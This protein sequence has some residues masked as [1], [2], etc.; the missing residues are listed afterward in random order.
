M[1]LLLQVHTAG[2]VMDRRWSDFLD[3]TL[4][5]TAHVQLQK[6]LSRGAPESCVGLHAVSVSPPP[7]CLPVHVSQQASAVEHAGW[8]PRERQGIQVFWGCPLPLHD[9]CLKACYLAGCCLLGGPK[10]PA[11]QVQATQCYACSY[12]RRAVTGILLL[13]LPDI[14]KTSVTFSACLQILTELTMPS[15]VCGRHQSDYWCWVH[16]LCCARNWVHCLLQL[17]AKHL[18]HLGEFGTTPAKPFVAEPTCWNSRTPLPSSKLHLFHNCCLQAGDSDGFWL[19]WD[20]LVLGAM[21]IST[22][23]YAVYAFGYT[24]FYSLP[25]NYDVYDDIG[26]APARLL[27]PS[28]KGP[29]SNNTVPRRQL[30]AAAESRATWGSTPG[31]PGRWTLPDDETGASQRNFR[32]TMTLHEQA[33]KQ[34]Q[35]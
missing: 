32:Q 18:Y 34:P 7:G 20:A 15:L 21:I 13:C 30:S 25:D 14:A 33:V 1:L 10:P 5:S 22:I 12:T 28:K 4:L 23:I 6:T 16:V 29:D 9:G 26:S 19:T 11:N 24:A 2:A 3:T 35:T 17:A 31:G 27:L 8:L